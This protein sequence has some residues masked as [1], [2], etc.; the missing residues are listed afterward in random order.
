MPKCS[1]CLAI[2]LIRKNILSP[3][4]QK[5][6]DHYGSLKF[7]LSEFQMIYLCTFFHLKWC[8]YRRRCQQFVF[9]P[10]KESLTKA[11]ISCP[12]KM[13]L[14]EHK[15]FSMLTA[16]YNNSIQSVGKTMFNRKHILLLTF[17]D[18]AFSNI[19]LF[20][21]NNRSNRKRCVTVVVLVFHC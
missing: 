5:I 3:S 13:Q 14:A 17:E 2:S 6:V 19:N 7:H 1:K 16:I 12:R 15:S 10:M 18:Y 21:V 20:K 8:K 4:N 11:F 9:K